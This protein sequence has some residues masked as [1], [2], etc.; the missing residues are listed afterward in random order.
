MSNISAVPRN[1]SP[2]EAPG[3][4]PTTSQERNI[5]A[6]Q[7]LLDIYDARGSGVFKLS[8]GAMASVGRAKDGQV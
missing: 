8:D 1:L 5:A 3:R 2:A 7:T 4:E 6:R